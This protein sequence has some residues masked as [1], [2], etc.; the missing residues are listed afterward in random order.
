MFAKRGDIQ[1]LRL[2]LQLSLAVSPCVL[3]LNTQLH[4]QNVNRVA[5]LEVSTIHPWYS[6]LNFGC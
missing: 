3:F 5:I 4:T 2:P 6:H 1:G